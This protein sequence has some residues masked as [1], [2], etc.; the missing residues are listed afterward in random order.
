MTLQDMLEAGWKVD[1]DGH[2]IDDNGERLKVAD[3]IEHLSAREAV[4]RAHSKGYINED[5]GKVPEDTVTAETLAYFLETGVVL[6]VEPSQ[7]TN[8]GKILHKMKQSLM[9]FLGF[10]NVIPFKKFNMSMQD[11]QDMALGLAKVELESGLRVGRKPQSQKVYKAIRKAT[12]GDRANFQELLRIASDG[13]DADR[14]KFIESLETEATQRF[15]QQPADPTNARDWAAEIDAAA[16]R[17]FPKDKGKYV[18]ND[19]SRVPLSEWGNFQKAKHREEKSFRAAAKLHVER[20]LRDAAKN[21]SRMANPEGKSYKSFSGEENNQSKKEAKKDRQKV[22]ENYSAGFLSMYDTLAD[23]IKAAQKSLRFKG[24]FINKYAAALPGLKAAADVILA[25]SKLARN[26]KKKVDNIAVLERV[27]KPDRRKVVNKIIEVATSKQLWPSQMRPT[28]DKDGNEVPRRKI[29]V[30]AD[31]KKLFEKLLSP[32]EQA[33]VMEV[34]EHGEDMIQMYREIAKELGLANDF[35]SIV[36]L[37]GPYAPLRRFGKHTVTLRSQTIIDLE[38]KLEEGGLPPYEK[39]RVTARIKE[40]RSNG[41]HFWYEHFPNAGQAKRFQRAQKKTGNWGDTSYAKKAVA[42]GDRG[43]ADQKVLEQINA[44]LNLAEMDSVAKAQFK[45]IIDE[46]YTASIAESNARQGQQLRQNIK[47][48]EQNMLRSFVVNASSEANLIA[49]LKYGREINIAIATVN[50]NANEIDRRKDTPDGAMRNVYNM[51]AN[52]YNI[53]LRKHHHPLVDSIASFITAWLLTTSLSYHLQNGTQTGAVAVPIIAADFKSYWKVMKQ[54]P[55]SYR[56][57]HN[58]IS[59]DKKIPFIGSKVATWTLNIN[60]EDLREE[61]EW[62][63]PILALLDEM[64]ILDLGIEQ[65]LNDTNTQDTGFAAA[66]KGIRVA[67]TISH[68][69]YQVPRGVEAYNRIATALTAYRLALDNPKVMKILKTNPLDYAIKKTQDTQGDFTADGAPYALKWVL[70]NVPGGK[71]VMQYKKFPL[72]MVWNYSRSIHMAFAGESK[73]QRAIGRRATRNLL[74]H[75]FVLSGVRGL[76]AIASIYG[77]SVFLMALFGD[78]EDD[79]PDSNPLLTDGAFERAIIEAFPDNPKLAEAI[80]RGSFSAYLGVDTSMKLSHDKIF[81]A[82]PYTDLE[83]SEEGFKDIG[84]GLMGPFGNVAMNA[85]IAGEHF[86]NGNT[87]RGIEMLMPKGLRDPMEA[88]R[89]HTEGYTTRTNRILA[90]PTDFKTM[91][92]LLK[93][94]GIPSREIG[95]LKWKRSE[96]YQIEKF[97]ADRQADLLRQYEKATS[98]DNYE[99]VDRIFAEW[100]A[101]QDGKDNIR[102]FF[103]FAPSAIPRTSI[104][105]VLDVP[106]NKWRYEQDAQEKLGT[107]V[108]RTE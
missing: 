103:N 63:L 10:F 100:D 44:A 90:P 108:W 67:G 58:V 80:Y 59:Y 92:L 33:I 83:I 22:K 43:T 47:G 19:G 101:I 32:A 26:I 20:M 23:G 91:D 76:P 18:P 54:L 93:S 82:L 12:T 36:Q 81:S 25:S 52:H 7:T 51:L 79:D 74:A 98:N 15:A 68:R 17:K 6:G 30:D 14:A 70:E 39:R 96:Q 27:L 94:L 35:F 89:F 21:E 46:I 87:Y 40:L 24:D 38:N 88:W 49:N 41:K 95:R 102:H 77:M 57:G 104:K 31:F 61:D 78:E 50:K 3:S 65:D 48:A 75:T 106:I 72:L 29:T 66:D 107:G 9:K 13:T 69:L 16:R 105:S 55:Q 53:R 97:F 2:M 5:I 84:V 42:L 86:S 37:E 45:R 71:L 4:R 85:A 8:T 64:E 28:K 73:E 1:T 11:F 56:I 34:F 62:A 99:E 60:L